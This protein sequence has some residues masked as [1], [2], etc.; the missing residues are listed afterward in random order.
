MANPPPNCAQLMLHMHLFYLFHNFK[1]T[2]HKKM[3]MKKNNL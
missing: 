3:N 2:K 1:I